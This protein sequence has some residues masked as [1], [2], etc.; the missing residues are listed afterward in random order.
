[1]KYITGWHALAIENQEYERKLNID[2]IKQ[3]GIIE[4]QESNKSLLGDYGIDLSKI[5]YI[6]EEK[7][8][9]NELY[10]LANPVRATLDMM[11][12]NRYVEIMGISSIYPG[13]NFREALFNKVKEIW[14]KVS[15][16]ERQEINKFLLIEYKIMWINFEILN[17]IKIK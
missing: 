14:D 17:N 6:I 15:D 13:R 4:M 9:K 12:H 1:M 11:L 8:I 5:P 7:P 2:H 10:Y 3:Y 16:T